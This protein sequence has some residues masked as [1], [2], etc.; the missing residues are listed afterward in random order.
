LFERLAIR[1]IARIDVFGGE[2]SNRRSRD[3][4][5]RTTQPGVGRD[6]VHAAADNGIADLRRNGEM[7]GVLEFSAEVQAAD[8]RKQLAQRN[9]FCGSKFPRHLR[10]GSRGKDLPTARTVTVSRGQEKYARRS[11]IDLHQKT[12]SPQRTQWT[13]R[14]LTKIRSTAN[15]LCVLCVLS[16]KRGWHKRS[17]SPPDQHGAHGKPGTD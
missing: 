9:T 11:A 2:A 5:I 13:P 12:I 6:H 14:H 8:E 4:R 3:A 1:P 7:P 17:D 16:G 10:I 15:E